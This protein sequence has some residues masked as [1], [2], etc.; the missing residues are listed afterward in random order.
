MGDKVMNELSQLITFLK[1]YSLAEGFG[2]N[3]NILETN[4][5]KLVIVIGILIYFGKRVCAN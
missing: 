4:L 1:S 2:L 3:T 5:I